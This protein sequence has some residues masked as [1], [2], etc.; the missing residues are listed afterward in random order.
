[1][2]RPGFVKLRRYAAL[3]LLQDDPKSFLLLSLISLRARWSNTGVNPYNLRPGE[4][5]I[6]DPE[7]CGLTRQQ[8]RTARE[9]LERYGF[10]TFRPTNRG[11]IARITESAPYEIFGEAA[12][13][14]A[15]NGQPASNQLATTNE[16]RGEGEEGKRRDEEYCLS[17]YPAVE[18]PVPLWLARDLADTLGL[19]RSDVEALWHY[20]ASMGWRTDEGR[21]AA[22]TRSS[23]RSVFKRYGNYR[24][25]GAWRKSPAAKPKPADT[26]V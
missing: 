7:T 18:E 14:P 17:Q 3:E 6:G 1:M 11:T 2:T 21:G 4:A 23:W 16:E 26:Q 24:N 5:L 8:Y 12:N 10:A 13:Q 19:T 22:I 25:G 20:C 9:R 15:T